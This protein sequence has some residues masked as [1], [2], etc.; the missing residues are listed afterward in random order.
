VSSS[1]STSY[2]RRVIVDL[3]PVMSREWVKDR[4]ALTRLFVTQIFSNGYASNGGDR[5]TS[6]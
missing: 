6:T 3:K 2:T 5:K 4:E 1:C